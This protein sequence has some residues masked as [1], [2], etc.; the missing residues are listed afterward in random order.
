MK[1]IYPDQ[2]EMI[3]RC[4]Q[5]V[6][7]KSSGF[8]DAFSKIMG[9]APKL[10]SNA[11]VLMASW[12]D[13]PLGPMLVIADEKWLYLLEFVDRRGLEREIERLRNKTKSAIIPGRTAIISSIEKE[14][15]DYFQG[16]LKQFKTPIFLLGSVFQK[17]VWAELMKIPSGE[18][19]SYAQI[20]KAI[21]HPDA[22]R[23]VGTANG[24]NQI[25]I[26]IPCHR[27]INSNGDLGGYGGGIARKEWL[28]HREK[29]E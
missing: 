20:A 24:L 8:R 16:K 4:K 14:L 2:W 27:V 11:N 5:Y 29:G 9:N 17:R 25:A 26:V 15:K 23:A 3:E 18:T 1:I 22:C 6:G 12:L 10:S 19:R 28:L 21:S 13:T 7:D